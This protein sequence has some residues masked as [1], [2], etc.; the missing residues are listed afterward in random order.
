M[1]VIHINP[2]VGSDANDGSKGSPVETMDGALAIVVAGDEIVVAPTDAPTVLA[3]NTPIFPDNVTVR[4]EHRLYSVLHLTGHEVEFMV[5]DGFVMR[6]LL[7]NMF[8]QGS[9]R[10]TTRF[11]PAADPNQIVLQDLVIDDLRQRTNANFGGGWCGT[12]GRWHS[13]T[14]TEVN[15]EM[16]RCTWRRLCSEADIGTPTFISDSPG[17]QVFKEC[18]FDFFET[19]LLPT[20]PLEEVS[21]S[22]NPAFLDCLFYNRQ[23]VDVEFQG[24]VY[25]GGGYYGGFTLNGGGI[26]TSNF[27]QVD[28]RFVDAPRGQLALRPD[29]P[30][31]TERLA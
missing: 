31:M 25:E 19:P 3:N 28:P 24:G 16:L 23:D 11:Q 12:T 7:L 27:M 17:V 21:R 4:G 29:S 13:G 18:T 14:A 15:I 5:G 8:G 6:D 26:S 9:S 1:A 20:V 30:F 10:E 22:S 2:E